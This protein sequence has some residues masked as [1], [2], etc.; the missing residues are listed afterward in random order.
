MALEE[1]RLRLQGDLDRLRAPE[2]YLRA[3]WPRY[4]TLF[5]RDSLIAAWQ[6]LRIDASVA[7]ATLQVLAM[8]QGCEIDTA[9]EQEPGKILH[10]YRFDAASQAE[11]PGWVFPYY[12]SVDSTLLY[13]FV[14][15]EYLDSTRDE[16]SIADL[17]PALQQAHGWIGTYGD[18]DG[19]GFVEYARKNPAGLFHQGWKD[20]SAD[21]LQIHPPV[22]LV[23]VQGYAFAAHRAFAR[24][25][26][27]LGRSDIAA[28]ADEAAN[29]LR[30][31]VNR[32][33]WWPEEG[34]YF[35]AL[36][37]DK[38]PRRA[39][40]SNPGHLLFAGILDADRRGDVVR[41]L[42][43][44]DLWTPYGIRTH[45]TS[46]PD[47]DPFSYHLGS[48]W[49]HDN[50]IIW[51]GLRASGFLREAEAVREALVRACEA[52]GR[53][54]ELYAV[55]DRKIVDL[56]S[57]SIGGNRANPVQAWSI[58]ALLD[59]LGTDEST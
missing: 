42:F 18:A 34:T 5:G 4:H 2:G 28:D 58:G 9:S 17:W 47:F 22:A 55:V 57:E 50:W 56:S 30:E 45:A 52:L 33:F 49:P 31:L 29:R 1:L 24:I 23:E 43:E 11:L 6:T 27:R 12:G 25:A 51:K 48:V 38:R 54:P 16:A 44:D 39:V 10:E 37:G 40:T 8:Y 20:G 59:M 7:R 19:D 14:A 26:S 46:E 21:H 32:A 35:L 3:G 36:D 15:G 53:L 41:R 13:L